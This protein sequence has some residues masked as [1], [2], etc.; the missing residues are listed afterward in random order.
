[1]LWL[2]AGGFGMRQHRQIHVWI[3]ESDYLRLRE[4]STEEKKSVS[5]IL[6]RLIGEQVRDE[7]VS[8][9]SAALEDQLGALQ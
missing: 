4:R 3:T 6:R 5:A 9:L 1:L 7:P 2:R 8:Q